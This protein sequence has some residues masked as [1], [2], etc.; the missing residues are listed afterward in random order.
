MKRLVLSLLLL[1]GCNEE[2]RTAQA[3]KNEALQDSIAIEEQAFRHSMDSLEHLLTNAKRDL[4]D[5]KNRKQTSRHKS[6]N[7]C[8]HFRRLV[9]KRLFKFV[10]FFRFHRT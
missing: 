4:S 7:R 1:L 10:R 2:E 9:P 8:G 5:E 6:V 3:K